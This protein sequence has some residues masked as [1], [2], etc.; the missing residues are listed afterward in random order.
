MRAG[1]KSSIFLVLLGWQ[2]GLPSAPWLPAA[3]PPGCRGGR[4]PGHAGRDRGDRWTVAAADEAPEGPSPRGLAPGAGPPAC[5]PG[6]PLP[7]AVP[8]WGDAAAFTALLWS[9]SASSCAR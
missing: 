2:R 3:L 1:D 6:P 9:S 5:G 4:G 7:A 8:G